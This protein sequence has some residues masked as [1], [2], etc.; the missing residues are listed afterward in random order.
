MKDLMYTSLFL[1]GL[2]LVVYAGLE[3]SEATAWVAIGSYFFVV[4]AINYQDE[5]S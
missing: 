1:G 3:V 5:L 2:V 4:A